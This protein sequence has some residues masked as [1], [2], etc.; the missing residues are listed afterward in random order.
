LV[1]R[2]KHVKPEAFDWS[3]VG[4]PL[5]LVAGTGCPA[6]IDKKLATSAVQADRFPAG[7]S[8]ARVVR[9]PEASGSV[10]ESAEADVPGEIDSFIPTLRRTSTRCPQA[11]PGDPRHA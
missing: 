1:A 4:R 10:A 9:L 2:D 6:L 3:G 5:L 11:V 8:S 7:N